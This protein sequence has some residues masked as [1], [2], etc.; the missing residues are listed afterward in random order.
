[1]W[2]SFCQQLHRC[3][4]HATLFMMA[5]LGV[6]VSALVAVWVEARVA[7]LEE[8]PVAALI[9]MGIAIGCLGT[10][11]IGVT[12]AL[13]WRRQRS[14]DEPTPLGPLSSDEWRV[15]RSKLLKKMK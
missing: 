3:G 10:A 1:M 14:N 13:C 11:S 4:R 9:W 15:A 6:F 5:L 8:L 12:L 2:N 7:N